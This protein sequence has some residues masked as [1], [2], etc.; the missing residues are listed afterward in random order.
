[1]RTEALALGVS[2][3]EF[4]RMTRTDYIDLVAAH[5]L[6]RERAYQDAIDAAEL[7]ALFIRAEKLD[8]AVLSVRQ[9]LVPNETYEAHAKQAGLHP[10]EE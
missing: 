9:A 7:I 6:R 3:A 5:N 4:E 2:L 10:P 8:E 1:M